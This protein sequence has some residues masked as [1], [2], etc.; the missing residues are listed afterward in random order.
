MSS[1]AQ[2]KQAK[3]A[4]I[5]QYTR[6]DSVKAAL[7]VAST[8]VPVVALWILVVPAA[9]TSWG[10]VAGITLVLTLFLIR[11]FVLMHECGHGSLFR[12]ARVN[13]AFGFVFGVISGMPQY[14]WSQHHAYHHSTNGN[15]DKYRGPLAIVT[16][17][18]YAAMTEAQRRSYRRARSIWMAPIAGLMY[19]LVHPRLNWIKGSLA[20]LGH[21]VRRKVAD[22]GT[23]LRAHAASFRTRYWAT[24]Q[25]YRHMTGNNVTLLAAW[26]AMSWTVGL[27]IFWPVYAASIALSGGAG[28]VLF[29]VQHNFEHSYA[30]ETRDWDYDTAA[31]EGTSFLVLPAWLNWFTANIAYHHI[32]HLSARIPNYCLARCHREQET[33]FRGVKRIRLTEIPSALRYILWDVR[34]RRLVSAA[35]F[36]GSRLAAGGDEAAH[37]PG[38]AGRGD[39]PDLPGRAGRRG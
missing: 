9:E 35:E 3:R 16:V 6:P 38:R 14:V 36:E 25:E 26:T 34:A 1:I 39:G 33:L 23:P 37:A 21:L 8:L 12:T 29:T 32:H 15:W 10:W 2:V 7:Q 17:D 28:I 27:E 4:L 30:S 24:A 13:N 20:F 5:Q 31:I 11:V 22:P 18:E 19:L